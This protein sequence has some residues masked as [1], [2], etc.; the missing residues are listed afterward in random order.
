M[1]YNGE[2]RLIENQLNIVEKRRRR[3]DDCELLEIIQPV[4]HEPVNDP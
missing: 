2:D 3:S 4:E 1:R